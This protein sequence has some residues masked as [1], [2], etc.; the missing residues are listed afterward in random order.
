MKLFGRTITKE[1]ID[2]DKLMESTAF[3]NMFGVDMKSRD[4]KETTLYTCLRILSDSVS[5]LPL[6]VHKDNG[7]DDSHYLNDILKLRPNRIMSAST[8]WR[9]IEYQVNWFGYS[10]VAI[11]KINNKVKS[12]IPLNMEHVTMYIDDVG[13]LD[14]KKEPIYFEYKQAGHEYLFQY[15][16]VL[17]F[18]GM[19]ADGIS[20]MPLKEQLKTLLENAEQAHRYTNFY[21]KNGLHSRGVVKYVGDL[22][23]QNQKEL[24]ARFN[25]VSGGIEKAGQLM[26]LPLGF[27]Y[28]SISTSLKDAQFTEIQELTER[29]IASSLGVKMHQLN[30]LERSTHSNIEHQQK[31]FY[32]ETLQ[33]KLTGYEQEIDYK[34]LTK[35]E[36]MNGMFIRFNV[37]A[38]LRSSLKERY[39]AFS[40]GVQGG[41]LKPNEARAKENLPPE[42]E[43]DRLYF[44][45]NMI[46]V[47]MAGKQ[48]LKGGEVDGQN[49]NKGIDN[50]AD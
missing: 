7:V 33:P 32:V 27:D 28:Q 21:L 30:N 37:D 25:R 5:K 6:K 16:E 26:P 9:T 15:D 45:G 44:N 4:F 35:N 29:Q 18:V 50:G 12:L 36:R 34:L 2:V 46:P 49:G 39:E 41:Y 17:Y 48:Y 1:D 23:E 22:S 10:V 13:L 14:N 19:T 3:Q 40:W 38:M 11:E 43:G 31:E 8:L 24:Q 42:P 20:P 47:E